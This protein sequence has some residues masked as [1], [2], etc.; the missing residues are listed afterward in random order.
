MTVPRPQVGGNVL[1]ARPWGDLPSASTAREARRIDDTTQPEAPD[2][3]AGR[4]RRRRTW[5]VAGTGLGLVLGIFGTLT[6]PDLLPDNP[7]DCV[8]PVRVV[9]SREG[10]GLMTELEWPD[11]TDNG[12][13]LRSVTF[14]EPVT[15]DER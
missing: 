13:V 12:C 11:D 2:E 7:P 1:S 14:Q 9:W 4:L 15:A 3:K 6:V 8:E 5:F 10:P